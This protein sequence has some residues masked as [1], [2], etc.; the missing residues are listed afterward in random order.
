[1]RDFKEF[2]GKTLDSAIESACDFYNL[3]R[4]KLEIEILSGGSTGIFGLMGVKKA[5]VKARPR[6][7][8]PV[9]PDFEEEEA[10]RQESVAASEPI[11]EGSSAPVEYEPDLESEPE[12]EQDLEPDSESEPV[13]EPSRA[14]DDEYESREPERP[15]FK[16]EE[17][18]IDR[19]QMMQITQE[20]LDS[21]LKE[22]I[23]ET[24]KLEMVFE[25]GRLD[26]FID[27]DEHSGLII[28]REGATLSS[29]QYLV[30]RIVSRRMG[31]GVRIQLDA[32]DY[33]E[34]QNERLRRIALQLADK[35]KA[36]NRTQSTRP[37][38][39]YHRRVVHLV[40]QADERIQT[41]SKGDG[42]MKRVLIMPKRGRGNS[43]QG[44]NHRSRQHQYR[45]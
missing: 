36:Q 9:H 16:K 27:D 4:D 45:Q 25:A 40:L 44:N 34:K 3:N 22:I 30:N 39:S 17:P 1:M 21:M 42:P 37:L 2:H 24:P 26:V 8:A 29:L 20:V 7:G 38:S 11:Q 43:H 6:A 41:R 23:D 19:E 15:A 14:G 33:R 28:G 35:A 5:K 31:E 12:A 32:G 10:M 13:E 18:E